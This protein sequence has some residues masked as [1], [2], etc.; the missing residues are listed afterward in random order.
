M[1]ADYLPVLGCSSSKCTA[2]SS[3][4]S[5]PA[6][7]RD[8]YLFVLYAPLPSERKS[9]ALARRQNP[10]GAIL[11][12]TEQIVTAVL[13]CL[14][15]DFP[16]ARLLLRSLISY[17]NPLKK[18]IIACPSR[19]IDW[20]ERNIHEFRN[21]LDIKLVDESILVPELNECWWVRGWVKQQLLK[22]AVAEV[23]ETNFY[24]TLDADVVLRRDVDFA[25]LILENKARYAFLHPTP[26]MSWYR[27]SWRV[28]GMKFKRSQMEHNVTPTVLS[29]CAV[30]KLARFLEKRAQQ[31]QES[32]GPK[33][34]IQRS[35]LNSKE[36]S[37]PHGTKSWTLLLAAFALWPISEWTEYSLYYSFLEEHQL[38]TNYHIETDEVFYDKE[39]SIHKKHADKFDK[40]DWKAV[41]QQTSPHEDCAKRP[42]FIIV[43]SVSKVP[44]EKIVGTFS[45]FL[46]EPGQ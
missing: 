9:G 22:L 18:L 20:F 25:D 26:H 1:R 10:I 32:K 36:K 8:L 19:Q 45:N 13:P 34:F 29:V 14:Q 31:I 30:K 3:N 40:I 35:I 16:R 27:G 23:I 44:L 15:Q 39:Q 11:T 21:Q 2:N 24:L 12:R 7:E 28:L 4:P 33:N 17:K 38:L 43:Q 46:Q 5:K 41:F 6:R 42:P 37:F